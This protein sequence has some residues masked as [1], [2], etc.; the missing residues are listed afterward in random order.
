MGPGALLARCILSNL[1]WTAKS[2]SKT[3]DRINGQHE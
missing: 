2:Y 1:L 3:L